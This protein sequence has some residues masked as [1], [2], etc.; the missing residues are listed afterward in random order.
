M[1]QSLGRLG[2]HGEP[3]P[4][5]MADLVRSLA[6]VMRQTSVSELDLNYGSVSIR[7]RRPAPS[8]SGESELAAC[9][10]VAG[11]ILN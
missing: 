2:R 10:V 5:R 6:A 4:E 9:A 3:S 8:T 1:S 7:L 11:L